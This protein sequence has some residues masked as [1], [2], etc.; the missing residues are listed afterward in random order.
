MNDLSKYKID[1]FRNEILK[2]NTLHKEM[3]IQKLKNNIKIFL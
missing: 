1:N 2:R 3:V